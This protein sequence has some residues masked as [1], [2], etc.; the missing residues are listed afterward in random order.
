MTEDH[1]K[2]CYELKKLLQNK[3]IKNSGLYLFGNL[4]NKAIAFITVPIFTRILST[5]E[6]GIVS[7]YSS[8]VS[9][10]A[11]IVGLSLGNSIRNAFVDYKEDLKSYISSVFTLSFLNFL[12]VLLIAI[13]VNLGTSFVNMTLLIMCLVESFGSFIINSIVIK[14]MMEEESFKRTILLVVPNLC[15]AIL[16]V[17][18]ILNMDSHKEYGRIIPMFLVTTLFG[19]TIF[20]VSIFRGRTF[21]KLEY[22]KYAL[23][24]SIPLIFH[25]LSVNI[26]STSDRMI[27]TAVNSA[28]ETGIYSVVYNFGMIATVIT[29]SIESVWIPYFTRKMISNDKQTINKSAK[30]YIELC[31]VIFCGILIVGPE[32]LVIFA[33]EKYRSGINVIAPVVLASY[34]QYMYSLAV[35]TEYYYKKTKIIATNTLT[36]ALINLLLNFIFIPFGGA[37]AAAFTTVVAY[38][39]SFSLHYRYCRKIDGELFPFSTFSVPL[40]VIIIFTIFQY[41]TLYTGMI[42]WILGLLS[43]AIYV[44]FIVLKEKQ[45]IMKILGKD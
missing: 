10:L 34:F 25:G 3:N 21:I 40:L 29:S 15:A 37:L 19:M 6:Y 42:R 1:L 36:A 38:F 45:I 14:Y 33:S 2:R 8:Y 30:L 5:E 41:L 28:S 17:F 43:V 12:L 9:L 44:V 16:S 31:T 11:V 20:I 39:V 24:I 18:F 13:G 4:F 32:V 27:L 23:N 26:L 22:W 7:T 35:D